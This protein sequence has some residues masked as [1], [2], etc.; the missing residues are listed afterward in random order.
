[1]LTFLYVAQILIALGVIALVML[2]ARSEGAGGMF[3]QG[4]G[5]ARTR[6]GVE[7]TIFN[8]TIGFAALFLLIAVITVIVQR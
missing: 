3:G 1:M 2:Q 7:R 5:I 8:L 6:R 4:D